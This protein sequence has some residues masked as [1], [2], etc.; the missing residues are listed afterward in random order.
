MR[1]WV[2]LLLTCAIAAACGGDG[3]PPDAATADAAARD[4]EVFA[5]AGPTVPCGAVTCNAAELC[6]VVP[7]GPCVFLDGGTCGATEEACQVGGAAGCTAPQA[8]SCVA[9]PAACAAQM[10]CACLIS[11]A[12][13][14]N[15]AGGDCRRPPGEGFTLSCPF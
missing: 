1:C 5:D 2:G 3:G 11:S 9:I 7:T 8:R 12:L 4:G 10:S 14:P 13:C 15:R 6:Q